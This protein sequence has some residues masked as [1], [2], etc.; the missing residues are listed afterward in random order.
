MFILMSIVHEVITTATS[1]LRKH[2]SKALS[3]T[4]KRCDHSDL[5]SLISSYI[6]FLADCYTSPSL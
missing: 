3:H 6:S 1:N 4:N 2:V 5:Y